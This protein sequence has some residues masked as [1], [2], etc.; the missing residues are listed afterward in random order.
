VRLQRLAIDSGGG[1]F[2]LERSSDLAST[3]RRVSEELHH[4]YVLAFAPTSADGRRHKLSFGAR[5][6]QT[7]YG[8]GPTE[9]SRGN[10]PAA[11][12]DSAGT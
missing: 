10:Q 12:R 7:R 6:E 9:L 2:D 11:T 1:Y 4:Q 5:Q 8:T 3:F